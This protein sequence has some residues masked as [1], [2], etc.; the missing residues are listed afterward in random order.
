VISST[1][2][3]SSLVT[4]GGSDVVTLLHARAVHQHDTLAYVFLADGE[5]EQVSLSYGEIDIRARVVGARLRSLRA[6]GERVLLLYPAGLDYVTAFFGCLYAEAVAVPLYPP[7]PNRTLVR[8]Q[9]VAADAGAKFALT[10]T[11]VLSRLDD[12]F[13]QT[14]GLSALTWITTDDLVVHDANRLLPPTPEPD[15]LAYLQ[16]TSGSTAT[17]KGIMVSHRNLLHNSAY[18]DAGWQH[19]EESRVVSWLPHFHDMGLVY[20]IVQPLYKGLP[21]YLMPP[22]VFLQRPL[23]WLR[24]ISQYRATHAAAPNFA[25]DLCTSKISTEE[26]EGLDLGSWQVAVNGAEPIRRSTLDRFTEKFAPYGFRAEAFC[27]GYG[28]AEAT[29]KVTASRVGDAPVFFTTESAALEQHRVIEAAE[30]QPQTQTLV[31]C[32]RIDPEMKV[33]VVDP[34]TGKKCGPE[35]VGEVWVSSASVAL[36]YWKRPEETESC[37]KAYLDNHL[38]GPYLRTGDLGFVYDGELFITGRL[39]DLIIIRGSNHYPQDLELTAEQ[40]HPDLRQGCGAAFSVEVVGEERLV[41]VYEV[42]RHYCE[43]NFEDVV[44]A[45]RTNVA[46]EHELQVYAIVLIRTGTI[47]KTSSGKIQRQACRASFLAGQL[48][49]VGSSILEEPEAVVIVEIPSLADLLAT[50][51]IER[52]RLLTTY[53]RDQAARLL[54]VSPAQFSL[55][56]PLNNF[57]LDSLAAL[58][59]RHCVE[60]Q[61]GVSLPAMSVF[62]GASIEDLTTEILNQLSSSESAVPSTY[63]FPRHV[64]GEHPLSYGQQALWLAYLLDPEGSSYNIS[65]A[66]HF[67]GEVDT[68]ALR[69]A[70]QALVYSHASLRTTYAV[71]DGKPV[72]LIREHQTVDFEC[73]DVSDVK[74]PELQTLCAEAD[75]PFDLEGG[76]VLRIKLFTR[77]AREHFLL[78]TVHHIACDFWSLDLLASEL[79]VRYEMEINETKA[80]VLPPELNYTDF[81]YWQADMLAG[82]EA[83]RLESYWSKQLE[84]EL[85][86]LNLP[87]DCS[88]PAA[89]SY[90][91]ASYR[92]EL[93]EQL[94]RGLADFARQ[95]GSTLYTTLLAC[96]Y[97]LLHRHSGQEDI[98]IGSPTSG[99]SRPE[100]RDIVG[101]LVNPVALRARLDGAADFRSF[102]QDVRATVINAL[103]HQDYPFSLIAEKLQPERDLSL[104]PLFQVVFAWEQPRQLQE[105][106]IARSKTDKLVPTSG[107]ARAVQMKDLFW[108]QGGAPYDLMLLALEERASLSLTFQYRTALFDESRIRLMAEHFQNLIAGV[109]ANPSLKLYELPMIGKEEHQQLVVDWN[110]TQAEYAREECLHAL[111]AKQAERTPD[112]VAITDAAQQMTYAELDRR[113]NQLAHYLRRLGVGPGAVAGLYLRRGPELLEAILAVMKAGGAY[114]PIDTALP[115]ERVR[116]TVEDSKALLVISAKREAVA[117]GSV[118]VPSVALDVQRPQI[119]SEPAEPL[120]IEVTGDNVAYV[121]YTS[122][123]TGKPKGVMVPH[124]GVVNLLTDFERRQPLD[125]GDAC[126]AWTTIGFDVSVYEIFSA[127]LAGG[128]LRF[129]PDSIRIHGADFLDWLERCKIQSAYVPPFVLVDLAERLKAATLRL[130]LKRLLVGV[131][132]I[133]EQ[134]LTEI[135]A[136]L[137]GLKIINGYGPTEASVCAT[138][139]DVNGDNA[140]PGNTPIGRPVQNMQVYLLDDHLNPVQVGTPAQLYIGG[141]GLALGYLGQPELTADR[142]VPCPFVF[143]PG[144]RMYKS[145]DLARHL[146]DGN[147]EFLGRLDQQIK[148]RGVRIEPGEIE[149][150]LNQ[151]PAV[152]DSVILAADARGEKYLVAYVVPSQEHRATPSELRRYLQGKLPGFMTPSAFVILESLPQT[153]HGK[154]DRRNLPAP[155]EHDFV[156]AESFVAPRTPVEELLVGIWQEVLGIEHVGVD[157][158][159]FDLG[160]HSLLATQITSRIH[161]AFKVQIPLPSFFET[162]NVCGLAGKIESAICSVRDFEMPAIQRAS[163]DNGLPLSFAQRRLWF[164]E[165]MEPGTPLY[166]IPFA[167]RLDGPLN[168]HAL[169][170]GASEIIKRHESLRTGFKGEEEPL[171]FICPAKQ[172]RL[173]LVDLSDLSEERQAQ[174][175]SKLIREENKR[176]FDL[177]QP[178][179]IRFHLLRHSPTKHLLLLSL[180]HLAADGWSVRLLL[181]ELGEFYEASLAS[182]SPDLLEP[183]LQYADYAAW[184]QEAFAPKALDRQSDYWREQLAGAPPL[185]ELPADRSRH[186]HQSWR[187]ACEPVLLGLELTNA[188]RAM[189]R[190]ENTTLFMT[191]LA[192]FQ[193]LISR[194]AGIADVVVGTPVANRTPREVES[195]VGL[196]A[197]VV[198]LRT[199]MSGDPTF[200]ELLA[201]VRTVCL[202]AYEHESYPFERLVQETG[203]GGRTLSHAPLVQVV[204]A[205]QEQPLQKSQW[206]DMQVSPLSYNGRVA[207]FDLALLL[208]ESHES[209]NGEGTWLQ[210]W[211]EYRTELFDARRVTRMVEHLRNLLNAVVANPTLRISRIP[212]LGEEERHQIVSG[213]NQ[214]QAAC[215]VGLVQELFEWQA[216][217]TPDAVAAED[218]SGHVTYIQLDRRSNQIARYLRRLGVG[219]ET[220]V[221]LYLPRSLRL[222]EAALGVLKAGGAYLPL[223]VNSPAERLQL[224]IEDAHAVAVIS[225]SGLEEKLKQVSTTIVGLD[226]AYDHIKRESGKTLL[227]GSNESNLAYVIYTSGSTGRPKGVQITHQGLMNLIRWHQNCFGIAPED[228]ATILASPAFDA[229][230][231][232]LWPYLTVGASVHVAE[233]ETQYSAV[234]L[235]DWLI[236]NGITITFTPTPLAE[237]LLTLE[238]PKQVSLHTMLT[239]G[240]KL[241]RYPSHEQ[242][243]NLV[244]NYG[245]TEVSVVATSGLISAKD[246]SISPPV[247]GRPIANTQAYVLDSLLSPVP[248][249]VPGQLALTGQGVMRGYLGRPDLTADRLRPDPFGGEPGGRLYLTGDLVRHLRDGR[250]EF[251]GRI[252]RQL[253]LR[254]LR[255]EPGEVESALCEHPRIRRAVVEIEGAGNGS[256]DRLVAY[257]VGESDGA[258]AHSDLRD[259]LQARVPDYMIPS[260][261]VWLE[262]LPLTESGK[263]DHAKLPKSEAGSEESHKIEFG[264]RNAAEE[265]LVTIWQDVLG[266]EGVGIHDDFFALGGHSLLAARVTS[267]VRERL[268]V[269]VGVRQL[270]ER[271]TVAGFSAA[272]DQLNKPSQRIAPPISRLSR[273]LYRAKVP[274]HGQFE[275]P[276]A[277]RKH[278]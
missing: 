262:E 166:N 178:P 153:R 35:E 30:G 246:R 144:A 230:V 232:E 19:T 253:K 213:W 69:R 123:S 133:K 84:G 159:F 131:E 13:V 170:Q 163:R 241:H 256:L 92:F 90:K 225:E 143:E 88:Q 193:A 130:A 182:R 9:Q 165:Q 219:P 264:P 249:G 110:Q 132:P 141:E 270:F 136:H 169:E 202:K 161:Q 187:G 39:K 106:E 138:L 107:T 277:L 1:D 238:W 156:H 103:A 55:Q 38:D 100:F 115:P 158:D 223:D 78:L 119:A 5:T 72:Q 137:P 66:V 209:E 207:K 80:T 272:L 40:S 86:V 74:D 140:R 104:S 227:G 47:H 186:A 150:V 63:E 278:L 199:N 168:I 126:S 98:I 175:S 212:L 76:E 248:A 43:T 160:G 224:M 67:A 147:V 220:I 200:R 77:S 183:R 235:R 3:A 45:I 113:S 275:I 82:S 117:L 26:C 173:R 252:D 216:A 203:S 83:E 122:G 116:V 16:Y 128:T 148:I 174:V 24:A 85:P 211:M 33:A 234:L 151:S 125:V 269:D 17:P 29:L 2:S 210:G 8:L 221:A 261:Y 44:S 109:V 27:P 218:V 263:I 204:I 28:L 179:L 32:G 54:K 124:R 118:D 226:V 51:G 53:L 185:L 206:G 93:R 81:T 236:Y 134:T 176:P 215:E 111:F 217:Q 31:G 57:G 52:R 201:R 181:S 95:E 41:I 196:F 184:Q 114:L 129:V 10:T 56:R 190:A 96:F 139:F 255:I 247:I 254:G 155:L 265:V 62:S 233:P 273:D 48:N 135:V 22:A 58:E 23:L 14:S 142:F 145:G 244:N 229:S 49:V 251:L 157:D 268:G 266:I 171:Q 6:K 146:P 127:L 267:R 36:G 237:C 11:Q 99:R 87:V 102:L 120:T 276:D 242:G 25:Y 240:D 20:G 15:A 231:W 70:C 7:R 167:M 222:I 46:E 68:A 180:H 108:R 208:G 228:R 172:L 64:I 4:A 59:L 71:R 89:Q 198:P 259:H 195:V 18:L 60:S 164:L 205:M 250:L 257:I 197:N 192:G 73:V 65:Y 37:F 177:T 189:S 152:H 214:T 79:R 97:V 271:P 101:N 12:L 121:M 75:R 154:I 194:Y 42:N 274:V 61:L 243:F 239:G 149:T 191:L 245:P 94:R 112:A 258:E 105:A 50:R 21:A 91:G 34:R 188:L 260:R 162:P